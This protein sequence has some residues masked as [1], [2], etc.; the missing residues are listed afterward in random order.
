M[1]SG[2]IL[3]SAGL[4]MSKQTSILLSHL[5]RFRVVRSQRFLMKHD[6]TLIEL[7]CLR[8]TSLGLIELGQAVQMSSEA[9]M[10]RSQALFL[11]LYRLLVERFGLR[12][13]PSRV[14][15]FGQVA[16][17]QSEAWM[18]RGEP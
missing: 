6:G 4:H 9:W 14:C 11:D 1:Y 8:I 10:F 17:G 15:Q 13:L 3:R 7:G 18:I 2:E 5:H 12:V 16:I